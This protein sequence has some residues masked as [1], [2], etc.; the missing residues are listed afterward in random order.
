MRS[1]GSSRLVQDAHPSLPGYVFKQDAL[2][3]QALT[4]RSSNAVHNER[5]EFLGDAVLSLLVADELYRRYPGADEG[6]LSCLRAA[7]VDGCTLTRLAK[8]LSLDARLRTGS[9]V[10]QI[11]DAM[12]A[13]AMEAVI[14][15]VYLDAG[16][17][18]C[19]ELVLGWLQREL[20]GL[21]QQH[22]GKSAK[23]QL[24]EYMQARGEPLPVYRLLGE[25]G[26]P[27]ER[28]Y[29]VLCETVGGHATARAPSKNRAGQQAA[30]ALLR[31]LDAGTDRSPQLEL[32]ECLR[33][34]G[35]SPAVY[36]VLEIAGAEQAGEC[37]IVC[38]VK[39][40]GQ[41][42]STRGLGD[43]AAAEAQAAERMLAWLRER[44][45]VA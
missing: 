35:Y 40:V 11:S 36:R 39:D 20:A 38:E 30:Q 2:L 33:C 41:G 14:G 12:L 15:A 45:E 42:A 43:Q 44:G 23:N 5:L 3:A 8:R 25:H 17:D 19:R 31:R 24:Q 6:Q 16:L 18:R 29:T 22:S 26:K 7:V 1:A 4:H 32:A 13:D 10:L 28:E 27:H 21:S 34:L 37:T 9:G